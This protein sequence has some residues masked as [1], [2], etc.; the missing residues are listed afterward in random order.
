MIKVFLVGTAEELFQ[1]NISLAPSIG[2]E[3]ILDDEPYLVT[4]RRFMLEDTPSDIKNVD[5]TILYV[6][7]NL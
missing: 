1:L 4:G 2:D 3:L 7:K 6:Q 5:Y